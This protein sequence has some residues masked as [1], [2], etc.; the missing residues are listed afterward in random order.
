MLVL[1]HKEM[2]PAVHSNISVTY[3]NRLLCASFLY[4]LMLG[5]I[6]NQFWYFA[7]LCFFPKVSHSIGASSFFP[8]T[9]C[10]LIAG[11]SQVLGLSPFLLSWYNHV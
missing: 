4:P 2:S 9:M 7:L 3:E 8:N 11:K 1:F 5:Q 6:V 10:C